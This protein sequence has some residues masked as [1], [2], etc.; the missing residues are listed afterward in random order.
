MALFRN[1]KM[2]R[3]ESGMRKLFAAGALF[4]CATVA[5]LNVATVQAQ[6]YPNRPIRLIVP[7]P[8]G[9]TND[10]MARI[11]AQNVE[12]QTG[13]AVVVDNRGGA[14]GVIGAQAV[15][16]ADP[17]GYTIM[18]NSSSFTINPAIRKSLPYD[19]LN[20][21]APV[22]NMAIGTG[23]LVIVHPELP[24][25]NIAELIA[26]AKNN[27]VLYGSA[28][29]GNPLQLAAAL[30]AVHANITLESVPFRGTAPALN[31]LLAN[32]IQI[33][34]VPPASVIGYI[35]AGQMR[36]IGFTG[37]KRSA[38]FP[39]VPLVR[40]TVPSY[41]VLGAWHGW[42]APAKTPPEVVKALSA[43]ALNTL[44]S[45]KVVALVRK[46]GY[47]PYPKGPAEFASLLKQNVRDM[48]DAVKAA[49]IEPQ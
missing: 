39:D 47:E 24:I 48:A 2:N 14:N 1:N 7:F 12:E 30:F 49:K 4:V 29:T 35:Q 8:A 31:A 5:A 9:G 21:F 41:K 20:D 38:D 43:L 16:T 28:G 34:F 25:R 19:V 23:Y 40:D 3:E 10:I 13:Q 36:A 17:D 45:P 42:L 46:S 15:A 22:A 6:P 37:E 44:D 11:F 32:T 33:M 18:H 26:Y 27:R